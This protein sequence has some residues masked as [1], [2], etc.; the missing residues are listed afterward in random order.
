M[1]E[2][3]EPF[4]VRARLFKLTAD[5]SRDQKAATVVG[6]LRLMGQRTGGGIGEP[7]YQAAVEYKA[8]SDAYR[9][10][11]SA[12]DSLRNASRAGIGAVDEAEHA[13]WCKAVIA[14]YEAS[15]RIVSHEQCVLA[16]RGM[17]LFAALDHM[18]LRDQ[19]YDHLV[20]DLRIALNALAKHYGMMGR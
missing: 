15:Q 4:A 13:R 20:G 7:Q 14:K 1:T 5:E 17:A 12:P 3:E 18:V 16:N 11:L 9:R 10:A 19:H 2:N 6:R 8:Q